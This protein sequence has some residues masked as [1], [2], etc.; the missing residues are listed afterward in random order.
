MARAS[1]GPPDPSKSHWVFACGKKGS[2]KSYT[3]RYWFESYP[4]DRVVI[5]PTHDLRADF[6][7][8]GLVFDELDAAALPVR[9]PADDEGRRR[10]W[11]F[12]PDMGSDTAVD[13][14][15]RVVG[16][17]FGR[18]PTLLW[19]DEFGR[20]TTAHRTPPNTR[21]LLH[22]GRHDDISLL[23][24]CPRPQDI[25]GLGISQ[26]D[27]IYIYRLPNPR[28]IERVANEAGVDPVELRAA[29]SRLDVEAHEYL[30]Y[31]ANADV[32]WLMPPLPKLR[33]GRNHYPP[34]AAPGDLAPELDE[35][36]TAA[37][38]D[39]LGRRGS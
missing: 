1:G 18:G 8:E 10:T 13:D 16:L 27:K 15:D 7:R 11:V 5:D 6:R 38:L 4:F 17:C 23:L 28:D 3:C 12:C 9:L 31:D 36:D 22:H 21:R 35:L 30:M 2:G 37:E 25:D 14:M 20:L 24:A 19:V 39:E 33:P 34:H 29:N 26:A 32:L